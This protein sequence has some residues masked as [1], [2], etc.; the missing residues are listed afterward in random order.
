MNFSKGTDTHT[1]NTC[2]LLKITKKYCCVHTIHKEAHCFGI[3][4]IKKSLSPPPY[5]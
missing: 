2:V 3:A 4:I 1:A 5:L